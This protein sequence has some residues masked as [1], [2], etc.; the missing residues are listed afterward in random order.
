M[1]QSDLPG[2]GDTCRLKFHQD[3]CKQMHIK[4]PSIDREICSVKKKK[5]FITAG[6]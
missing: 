5:K 4:K 6:K 2:L 3:K 1:L